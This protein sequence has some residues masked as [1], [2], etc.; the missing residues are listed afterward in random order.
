VRL[1]DASGDALCGGWNREQV[2]M[3]LRDSRIGSFGALALVLSVMQDSF[4]Y[5]FF[6]CIVLR[7]W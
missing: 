2:L 4:S 5:R 6:Q 3:I 1:A 7:L